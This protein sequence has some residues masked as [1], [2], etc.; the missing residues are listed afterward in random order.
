MANLNFIQDTVK[1]VDE[2]KKKERRYKMAMYFL[3]N[4]DK[5]SEWLI[6]ENLK[7]LYFYKDF[8]F[9][10]EAVKNLQ[11]KVKSDYLSKYIEQ[12]LDGTL[13]VNDIIKSQEKMAKQKEMK[14]NFR[15]RLQSQESENDVAN[16]MINLKNFCQKQVH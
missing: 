1:R 5:G 12:F 7:L 6:K 15:S 2:Q 16:D 4:H 9:V 13:D 14:N 11:E 10:L 3:R 8:D